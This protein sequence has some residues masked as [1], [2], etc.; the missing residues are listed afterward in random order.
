MLGIEFIKNM[1]SVQY[2]LPFCS[3]LAFL[4]LFGVE[5]I[6]FDQ[7]EAKAQNGKH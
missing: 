7:W 1:K 4:I 5:L 6:L 3:P 2:T